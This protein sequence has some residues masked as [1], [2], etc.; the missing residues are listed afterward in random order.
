MEI[1]EITLRLRNV[2]EQ[3][4]LLYSENTDLTGEQ[5]TQSRRLI[6]MQNSITE[7]L[8]VLQ[9]ERAQILETSR[10]RE[11][12]IRSQF[13]ERVREADSARLIT[14]GEL[15]LAVRELERLSGENDLISAADAQFSGALSAIASLIENRRFDQAASVIS[16]M[17]EFSNS[18]S[19]ASLGSFQSRRLYYNQS[20]D[21]LETL[22]N[23][24]RSMADS[25][26]GNQI[27]PAVNG[28]T[29][30]LTAENTRLQ[31]TAAQLQRTIDALNS[32]GSGQ[33]RR[34][35]ELE[36]AAS[37]LRENVS[38]LRGEISSLQQQTAE[39]DRTISALQGENTTLT[40]TAAE[41]RS[42]NAAHEQ[43][44]VSLRAQ[45]AAIRQ[46]MNAESTTPP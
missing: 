24:T 31:E 17:R 15:N 27:E 39:K 23:E 29:A 9:N 35:S 43:E 22:I 46:I 32:G 30:A 21:V 3:L 45:L 20:L 5:L 37:T 10:V 44:I 38:S 33:T 40:S 12:Q 7:E 11:A 4:S 18:S 28:Q 41:L 13:E 16:D 26:A 42:A 2:N 25:H 14:S 19:L 6:E 1:N 8:S 36:E 34:I